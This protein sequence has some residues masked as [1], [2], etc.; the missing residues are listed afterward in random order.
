MSKV[1]KLLVEH[2]AS[3]KRVDTLE[4]K[5]NLIIQAYKI[6][7]EGY[8]IPRRDQDIVELEKLGLV[9]ESLYSGSSVSFNGED[10]G[11]FCYRPADKR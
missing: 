8:F 5:L 2:Y 6:N 3:K 1:R 9:K 7:G 11:I 10:Y 4:N